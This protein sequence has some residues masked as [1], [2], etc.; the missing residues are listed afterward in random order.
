MIFAVVA[1]LAVTALGE[2]SVP[3]E[4]IFQSNKGLVVS[5]HTL[6][7]NQKS[8]TVVIDTPHL[9]NVERRV[10]EFLN[11]AIGPQWRTYLRP[12]DRVEKYPN[13][14][15]DD[16]GYFGYWCLLIG[17]ICMALSTLYFYMKAQAVTGSKFFEVLTMGITGIATLAYLLMF[18]GAGRMWVEEV[19]GTFSPVYW[20][21]YVDWVLTTPLMLWDILALAGAPNDEI[22]MVVIMDMLMIGFG[23]AGAVTPDQNK[24]FFF[25]FG[26]VTF[27]HIC[28]VLLKYSK[29][30]KYGEEARALYNKVAWMTIILWTLYPVVWIVAEGQRMVSASLE[31]CLY[32]I[33]DVSA[34]CVFGIL[35]VQARGALEA[36]NHGYKSMD[37]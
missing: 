9:H 21:R 6:G 2:G 7:D 1:L 28:A 15:K 8:G 36:I 24:W 23:C 35:I 14:V 3:G 5:G 11:S 16:L 18:T 19:P 31:A 29:V 27:I 22:A 17:F 37:A 26:M 12:I 13:P 34:K 25:I 4:D 32:A 20:G 10:E 33:M 30:N